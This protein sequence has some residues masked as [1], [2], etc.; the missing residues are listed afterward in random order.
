MYNFIVIIT[1]L[2]CIIFVSV[3]LADSDISNS[4]SFNERII[5]LQEGTQGLCSHME[6]QLLVTANKFKR[7]MRDAHTKCPNFNMMDVTLANIDMKANQHYS[8]LEEQLNGCRELSYMLTK[9]LE[10]GGLVAFYLMEGNYSLVSSIIDTWQRSFFK[11]RTR[12]YLTDTPLEIISQN[13]KVFYYDSWIAGIVQFIATWFALLAFSILIVFIIAQGFSKYLSSYMVPN[14]P[15]SILNVNSSRRLPVNDNTNLRQ[16]HINQKNNQSSDVSQYDGD[17]IAKVPMQPTSAGSYKHIRLIFWF[18]VFL[19]SIAGA[20]WWNPNLFSFPRPARYNWFPDATIIIDMMI[21]DRDNLQS[22]LKDHILSIE[23]LKRH[24]SMYHDKSVQ[25][26]VDELVRNLATG[27]RQV[28]KEITDLYVSSDKVVSTYRRTYELIESKAKKAGRLAEANDL[29]VAL[30]QSS[31]KY[32]ALQRSLL[33]LVTNQRK[34][35]PILKEQTQSLQALIQEGRL[36]EV[37]RIINHHQDVLLDIDGNTYRVQIQLNEIIEVVDNERT[38]GMKR[39]IKSLQEQAATDQIRA[40]VYG[41][42]GT[43][44]GTIIGA[45]AL[46]TGYAIVTVSATAVAGP[47]LIIGAVGMFGL[48]TWNAVYNFGNY[49]ASSN[50]NYELAALETERVNLKVAME[51]L[52]KAVADQQQALKWS[53]SSLGKIAQYCGEFS[54]IAGFTL[55][56]MHRNA[57]NEELLTITTQYNRMIVFYDLFESKIDKKRLPLPSS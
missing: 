34:V 56:R 35:L 57:I 55:N 14:Q 1:V 9:G 20:L 33:V 28:N 43:T 41:A 36:V 31:E 30:N 53:K 40:L 5:A 7:L 21:T 51:Q 2:S 27:V 38:D 49:Q 18:A 52:Q 22:N 24:A 39:T 42:V 10:S 44:S 37:G 50:F 19:I 11:F 8:F 16:R 26:N 6:K 23:E 4:T 3:T 32:E 13:S 54:K 46:K 12:F 48:A 45:L 15:V 29:L 25:K 47:I 17:S